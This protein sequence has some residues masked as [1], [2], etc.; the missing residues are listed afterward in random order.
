MDF[1][2]SLLQ[3]AT[4]TTGVQLL[5]L[6]G[7]LMFLGYLLSKIQYATHKNYTRLFGWH[8]LYFTAWIG[9]PVHELSHVIM[10]KIF[11]HKVHHVSL[12]SPNKQTGGLG[13]VEHSYSKK[14]IYQL[15]GNAFIGAAPMLIGPTIL[16]GLFWLLLPEMAITWQTLFHANSLIDIFSSLSQIGKTLISLSFSDWH[17]WIFLYLSFCIV[18]HM[19]PSK[20]DRKGMWVGLRWLIGIMIVGNFIALLVGVP[21][22][23]LTKNVTSFFSIYFTV[24]MYAALISIIH[25]AVT[26]IL[27]G[28]P[29]KL[30]RR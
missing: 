21:T 16:I 29:A 11:R 6:F 18:S 3:A 8:G 15:V 25:Y 1:F 27:F 12:F 14:S 17:V 5:A 30:L 13:H 10:A 20:P 19:A 2:F 9:T 7:F 23:V 4:Y 26:F 22:E 28:L 24:Y